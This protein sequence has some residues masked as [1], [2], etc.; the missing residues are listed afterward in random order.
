MTLQEL[1]EYF[2]R[3]YGRRN[4]IFL[5]S[6]VDRINFLNLAISDLQDAVRKSYGSEI[7]QIAF[8][9]ITARIFC[10]AEYLGSPLALVEMV[11]RKYGGGC[12]YCHRNPCG[13]GE[14]HGKLVLPA[15][16][17]QQQTRWGIRQFQSNLNNVFGEA[18]RKRGV[19]YVLNRLSREI[20][21]LLSLAMSPGAH[22]ESIEGIY[23]KYAEELA[24]T[25]AWTLTAANFLDV[26]V[27]DATRLR[28]TNGCWKCSR[29]PCV[30]MEF[31][32]R[33]VDW[34]EIES[35]MRREPRRVTV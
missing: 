24:D 16:V 23:E 12:A 2:F 4:R 22:G 29:C 8:A 20:A 7:R 27:H 25:F 34:S 5:P 28:Y 21:E 1:L 30:C 17:S 32:V 11:I 31:D 6:L 3:L 18:N 19:E 13:C 9:R 10:V 35:Q 14:R 33:Q 26:D 15:T